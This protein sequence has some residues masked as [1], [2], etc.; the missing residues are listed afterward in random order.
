M[1]SNKPR[2]S[3]DGINFKFYQVKEKINDQLNYLED[4]TEKYFPIEIVIDFNDHKDEIKILW[5]M[6]EKVVTSDQL[7][8]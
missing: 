7:A 1:Y 3:N 6:N 5:N 2:F 8:K 4:Q